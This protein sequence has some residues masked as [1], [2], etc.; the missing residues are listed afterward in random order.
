MKVCVDAAATAADK[1]MEDATAAEKQAWAKSCQA[2]A[3]AAFEAAGG[4]SSDFDIAQRQ[5]AEKKAADQMKVC[6]EA[7]A[8][9]A[10]KTMEDAT[11]AEKQAWAKSCQ[12][13]AKAAF[14]AAGGKSSDFDIAQRQGAEKKAADQMKVC[15][16]AQSRTRQMQKS[17]LGQRAVKL[18]RRPHSKRREAKRPTLRWP[19][20]RVRKRRRPSK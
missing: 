17:R 4:K 14:E 3:K 16:E 1:T 5:G 11:A 15:V 7:A 20:V 9:A 2:A 18:P 6:V 13:A 19:S 8:T 12:A 10:D